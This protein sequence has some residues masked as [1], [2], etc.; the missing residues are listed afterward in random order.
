MAGEKIAELEDGMQVDSTFLV[1]EKSDLLPYRGKEGYWFEMTLQDRTGRIKARF[2][3]SDDGVSEIHESINEVDVIRVR[4][5][6]KVYDG[7]LMLNIAQRLPDGSMSIE[8]VDGADVR[9][10]IPSVDSIPW[11]RRGYDDL[12]REFWELFGTVRNEDLRRI[13]S[14]FFSDEEFWK[15]F[16]TAPAAV[17]VHSAYVNGLLHHTVNVAR[18]ARA[19]A[20]GYPIVDMDLVV[21][22]A[23]LHDVGKVR[24]YGISYKIFETEEGGLFGHIFIGAEMVDQR[25]R[26][27][28]L[29]DRL[30]K[31]LVHIIL[32]H[33]G[34][35]SRGLGS[36][37]DPKFP[38]AIIVAMA[39]ESDAMA[40]QY[41]NAL[42][43]QELKRKK[44]EF[45]VNFR[46]LG[47][48]YPD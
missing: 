8:V 19:I 5:I 23:L 25:S 18:I 44:G 27:L 26:E 39:D 32:S 36:P 2:W 48:L 28:G 16:S 33:H 21:A 11:L 31:K 30:R 43:G 12:E 47:W 22:G 35:V 37:V 13:L 17:K 42:N 38:E 45:F 15:E 1:V 40:F 4:G 20:Q 7:E 9:D 34:R 14:S 10:Y 29:P 46:P 6:A 24:E 41:L 3:G